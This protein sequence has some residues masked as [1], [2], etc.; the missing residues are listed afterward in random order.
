MSKPAG[1]ELRR[2]KSASQLIK[3]VLRVGRAGITPA[4]VAVLEQA[5]T[6]H[7]LVKV[8]FDAFK[9]QRHELARAL[10]AQTASHVILQVGHVVTLF[11]RR[12]VESLATAAA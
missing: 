7:E 6:G 11:R 10:A 4:L 9:E 12:P 5:L 8:R 1:S 2:L 3:P